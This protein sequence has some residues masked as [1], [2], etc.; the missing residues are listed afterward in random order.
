L[1]WQ[2]LLKS[3][4]PSD[5]V[6]LFSMLSNYSTTNRL[7][8]IIATTNPNKK[9]AGK[10]KFKKFIEQYDDS[11]PETL[12]NS[13]GKVAKDMLG[14]KIEEIHDN[15]LAIKAALS[16]KMQPSRK[17]GDKL[18][19]FLVED[20]ETVEYLYNNFRKTRFKPMRSKATP[21]ELDK[22]L[23]L[24]TKYAEKPK[25]FAEFN[26]VLN[27][28]YA[29]LKIVVI[30]AKKD[31]VSGFESEKGPTKEATTF[32]KVIKDAKIEDIKKKEVKDLAKKLGMELR[33]GENYRME[34][35]ISE[36]MSKF[37]GKQRKTEG[38]KFQQAEEIKTYQVA[39]IGSNE[40]KAYFKLMT[41]QYKRQNL[42]TRLIT[43]DLNF[44]I[45]GEKVGHDNAKEL[46][47]MYKSNEQYRATDFMFELLSSQ[48]EGIKAAEDA[49]RA[50]VSGQRFEILPEEE[51]QEATEDASVKVL[52]PNDFIEAIGLQP[53]DFEEVGASIV[54][55][56]TALFDI[57]E[58][59]SEY[60]ET[61]R[62]IKD[63]YP[64]FDFDNAKG[65]YVETY[66]KSRKEAVEG[67]SV[68]INDPLNALIQIA[69][70]EN[71]GIISLS[72]DNKFRGEGRFEDSN[73]GILLLN[74]ITL[75]E[76]YGGGEAMDKG[77]EIYTPASKGKEAKVNSEA[78]KPFLDE[79]D[80]E[81][82]QL[83]TKF[84]DGIKNKLQ[85]IIDNPGKYPSI[86]GIKARQAKL[87]D[88]EQILPKEFFS[89]EVSKQQQDGKMVG[90]EVNLIRVV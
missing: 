48:K 8:D 52:V 16:K 24:F 76:K 23:K 15:F 66:F 30:G 79:L 58:S 27:F 62:E 41:T 65:L 17:E 14:S 71:K 56:D 47:I 84:K 89:V 34:K 61:P 43:N 78:K 64:D 10:R 67:A 82:K 68:D 90:T 83:S 63:N 33:E 59:I 37:L 31:S 85:S 72:D 77:E 21:D 35:T 70:E 57:N 49:L 86:Y 4:L 44:K 13:M 1:S 18:S 75:L 32:K 2:L 25:T 20:K 28:G 9:S 45:G 3:E 74:L 50:T 81:I 40:V 36:N 69:E 87:L 73:K 60:D 29:K 46:P 39:E 88:L 6:A 7:R 12:L 19:D 5:E 51:A 80:N 11:S 53:D 38:F 55:D 54:L 22:M 26:D 42:N